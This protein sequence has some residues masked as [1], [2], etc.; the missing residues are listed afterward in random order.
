MGRPTT[1]NNG[2]TTPANARKSAQTPSSKSKTETARQRQIRKRT[3]SDA[4]LNLSAN[5]PNAKNPNIQKETKGLT[6]Y[7][8]MKRRKPRDNVK[9]ESAPH[10]MQI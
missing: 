5:Q 6:F 2:P 7:T 10:L 9:S 3:A 1:R 4:D 8:K